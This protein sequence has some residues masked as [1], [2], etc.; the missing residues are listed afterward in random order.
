MC[1]IR[2]RI[3]FFALKKL[4]T[5]AFISETM[6]YW[7]IN[8]L[9]IIIHNLNSAES[10]RGEPGEPGEPGVRPGFLKL[11][12]IE[13]KYIKASPHSYSLEGMEFSFIRTEIV[14]FLV[15]WSA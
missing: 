6:R 10:I 12:H 5:R 2:I 14:H 15:C 7:Y 8:I 3:L 13:L 4:K 1:Y 11:K 9:K